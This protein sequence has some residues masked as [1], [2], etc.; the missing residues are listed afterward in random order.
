MFSF[1]MSAQIDIN[2]RN[3]DTLFIEE[4]SGNR[5]WNMLWEDRDLS[6]NNYNGRWKC[7]ADEYWKSG[8]TTKPEFHQAFRPENAVFYTDNSLRLIGEY[9]NSL[10]LKCRTNAVSPPYYEPAPWIKYCHECDPEQDEHPKI[11]YYSGMVET[12]DPVGY[13]YY[14]AKSKMPLHKGSCSTFWL[15][16]TLGNTYNEIDF[17]E[18]NSRLCTAGMERQ[19]SCGIWYNPEG[20][21]FGADSLG[22]YA[23]DIAREGPQLDVSSPA[24]DQYHTFGCLWM[25]DRVTWYIDGQEVNCYSDTAWIPKHP[26][27]L[28]IQHLE[29][30]S[31]KI[32]GSWWNGVDEMTIDYV[33]ALRLKTD[34][35]TNSVIR[36][37]NDLNG[38]VFAVKHSIAMG[39]LTGT[40]TAP[41]DACFTFRAVESI[42]I[43]GE[44]EVPVGTSLTLLT[45][46][47]PECSMEDVVLPAHDCGLDHNNIPINN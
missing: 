41:T 12:I 46:P 20:V 35:E 42:T 13:G 38:F 47:C 11:Y 5:Y 4:F 30:D 9:V 32:N 22:H 27:W 16:S 45:H 15:Y 28:K 18:H 1:D 23:H 7:F 6:S 40:L 14:E 26:M 36:T 33:K 29:D 3:W 31:A 24:L 44:F 34:C 10:G 37:A 39:S 17:F 43:D 19:I 2:D 21:S 8:V 25:P